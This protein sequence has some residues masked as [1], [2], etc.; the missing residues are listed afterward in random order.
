MIAKWKKCLLLIFDL[1]AIQLH[2][3]VFNKVA[4][5]CYYGVV[6]VVNIAHITD[7][8]AGGATDRTG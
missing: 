5:F 1:T 2:L 6:V 8:L 4:L 3:G 7:Q